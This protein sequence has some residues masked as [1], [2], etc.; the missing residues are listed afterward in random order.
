MRLSSFM[1]RGYALFDLD[2]TILPFDTQALFCNYVLQQEGWRRIYLAW[3]LLSLPLAA[4]KIF[5]L[6]MMKRV[7]MSYLVGME[8]ETLE[9]Y[10]KEFLE[11][12]F[13]QALYPEVVAEVERHREEGRTLILN[14]A[15]PDFY[16]AGISKK[17]GFDH[18]IGT[19]MTVE[20]TMPI[21]PRILGP[22]NK[23]EAK[24]KAM[25]ERELISCEA[26]MLANT[27]AY[28]DSSADMPLLSIAESGVMI[29]PGNRLAEEG[30]KQ[31]WRTMTP[32]R[33]YNGKWGGRWASVLQAMGFYRLK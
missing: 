23:C 28:S 7:F 32:K 15:S 31:G 1:P 33:P 30:L 4:L 26:E 9:R 18:Y 29:H 16:L 25:R 24:I 20:D 22:N 21:L 8:K 14:S 27:W 19:E 2:H 10:V 17:L 11:T 3:F 5:N 6:R 13:D 12:D